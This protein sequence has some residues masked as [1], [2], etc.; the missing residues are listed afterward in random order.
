MTV[1][2]RDAS[3]PLV[4]T[5]DAAMV[6]E[7]LRGDETYRQTDLFD[8]RP[9][10][11]TELVIE[12]EGRTIRFEK[13]VPPDA[14]DDADAPLVSTDDDVWRRVEPSPEEIERSRMDALLRGL[15]N[16]SAA[17]FA[18][19]RDGIGLDNPTLRV[20]ATFGDGEAETALISRTDD[21]A[22]GAHGDEP[23]VAILD[24]AAVDTALEAL[25]ALDPNV[26]SE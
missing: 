23:G 5:V 6:D 17:G 12:R 26:P 14:D 13:E 18:A 9:F 4:F 11:V 19:S 1:W 21:A 10:N 2:A 3:R 15:S 7:L 8:F 16:L 20:T 25:D 22:H 24:V